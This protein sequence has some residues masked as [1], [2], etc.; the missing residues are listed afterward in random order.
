MDGLRLLIWDLHLPRP[1]HPY[2]QI[3]PPTVF[4]SLSQFDHSQNTPDFKLS[5][6][7]TQP[8]QNDYAPTSPRAK[9]NNTEIQWDEPFDFDAFLNLP[10][11]VEAEHPNEA[12]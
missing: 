2:K 7:L 6:A 8:S 5:L 11:E 1:L 10:N 4:E 9:M 12:G 3:F